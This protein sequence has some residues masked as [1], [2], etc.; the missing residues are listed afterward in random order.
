MMHTVSFWDISIRQC[1]SLAYP[2]IL[3]NELLRQ[4]QQRNGRAKEF[5]LLKSTKD[6]DRK[7]PEKDFKTPFGEEKFNLLVNQNSV[8]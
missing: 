6:M 2:K 1:Q 4:Q 8:N 7:L 5:L 3:T